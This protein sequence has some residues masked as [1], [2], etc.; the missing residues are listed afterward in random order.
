MG[1][2]Q[3]SCPIRGVLPP[4]KLKWKSG[5]RD[6]STLPYPLAR[7][8]TFE[9][10][11]A[12]EDFRYYVYKNLHDNYLLDALL[13][14]ADLDEMLSSEIEFMRK[15]DDSTHQDVLKEIDAFEKVLATDVSFSISDVM[16]W[17]EQYL[18]MHTQIQL[19]PFF[20]AFHKRIAVLRGFDASIHAA[21]ASARIRKDF[22][23]YNPNALHSNSHPQILPLIAL[24]STGFA[25]LKLFPTLMASTHLSLHQDLLIAPVIALCEEIIRL[26]TLSLFLSWAPKPARPNKTL[27][28]LPS[29]LSSS[30]GDVSKSIDGL[31][32]SCWVCSD[33]RG[34]IRISLESPAPVRSV[35]INWT[36]FGSIQS[37][38]SCGAP[39]SLV[40]YGRRSHSGSLVRLKTFNV[41]EQKS[42][43]GSWKHDYPI[44]EDS[45]IHIELH[46]KGFAAA[47][48]SG[49]IKIY[50]IELICY[51]D[52]ALSVEPLSICAELQSR[53]F[54]LSN[55]EVL[56]PN[57]F[58][59]LVSLIRA[60]GSLGLLVRMLLFLE[61]RAGTIDLLSV[62]PRQVELLFEAIDATLDSTIREKESSLDNDSV[63]RFDTD[64]RSDGTELLD[65]NM[66]CKCS[67]AN[68][69]SPAYAQLSCIMTSGIWEWELTMFSDESS[70]ADVCAIG[71][72]LKPLSSITDGSNE[73]WLV[74]CWSG[75]SSFAFSDGYRRVEIVS[76]D[77]CR[78]VFDAS[79]GTLQLIVN[80]VDHGVIYSDIPP[81]VSPLVVFYDSF[82]CK[83]LNAKVCNNESF[84]CTNNKGGEVEIDNA[85]RQDNDAV[86]PLHASFAERTPTADTFDA[87]VLQRIAAIAAVR[88]EMS[89]HREFRQLEYPFAVEVS[90]VV[91]E[92]TF[93]LLATYLRKP[94]GHRYVQNVLQILETQFSNLGEILPN[95]IGYSLDID[96]SQSVENSVK[97]LNDLMEDS[98]AE[99]RVLAAKVY[100][101]GSAI[102]LPRLVE[103]MDLVS[104]LISSLIVGERVEPKY[105]LLSILLSQFSSYQSLLSIISLFVNEYTNAKIVHSIRNFCSNLVSLLTIPGFD[106]DEISATLY[107]MLI[108]FF[109]MLVIDIVN[110][111]KSITVSAPAAL[112]QYLVQQVLL[113]CIVDNRDA[114]NNNSLYPLLHPLLHA[115]IICCGN[116]A[117]VHSLHP[118]ITLFL[119]ESS[120]SMSTPECVGSWSLY[121]NS[122]P[123]LKYFPRFEGGDKG[124]LQINAF[125]VPDNSFTLE[126]GGCMYESVT[127]S[128]TCAVTNVTFC[129]PQR[130]AWEFELVGDS[131]GD[132][133]SVFGA[134]QIPL[135]SRCYSS[136]PD[137]WMRRSYNGYMYNRG[138]TLDSGNM[139]KIHPVCLTR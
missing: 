12:D 122:L 29:N 95:E 100:A 99:I 92:D 57:V 23:I 119:I 112:F 22:R 125:F 74:K 36:S 85:P 47:N 127:S 88:L 137:L 8:K 26:E 25:F 86:D 102:F 65:G 45:L 91:I 16:R 49:S 75:S 93:K 9:E 68:T 109:E 40:V 59:S 124:W 98:S 54:E 38:N 61:E 3:A 133:C 110:D 103:R 131:M 33:S 96:H 135:S 77:V 128:N 17:N 6:S 51:D 58:S 117:L 107:R 53:L 89:K 41:E 4:E 115:L 19:S 116:L 14:E 134:A 94:N 66:V 67:T 90:K 104:R 2:A 60:S 39:E 44:D 52:N 46:A 130:A 139:D 79:A 21:K 48:R 62:A 80:G 11:A 42:Q 82:G 118:Y 71:V 18:R 129:C 101:R 31:P 1:N 37:P 64:A 34:T 126:E 120:K 111:T 70:I 123:I 81:C 105:Q 76:N 84:P 138:R 78:F 136:S 132:E 73:M 5:V 69:T 56:R 27:R 50:E 10:L 43:Q 121:N 55:F 87:S 72:G 30:T 106:R 28:L 35:V 114:V 15:M 24:K 20:K 97:L 32:N 13:A 108:R 7:N 113:K 83:L 63:I